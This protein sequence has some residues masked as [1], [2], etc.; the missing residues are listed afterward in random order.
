MEQNQVNKIALFID[1]D[2]IGLSKG[3]I[4]KLISYVRKRGRLIV[5][6]AYADWS[7]FDSHKKELIENSI[8]LIE[9]PS[10]S[11]GKNAADIKLAVDAMEVARDKPYIDTMIIAGG[12]SDYMPLISKLRE[13]DKYVIVI[14]QR[15]DISKRLTGYSDEVVVVNDITDLKKAKVLPKTSLKGAYELLQES[16]EYLLS[17]S[18]KTVLGQVKNQMLLSDPSFNENALGFDRFISFLKKAAEDR[19]VYLEKDTNDTWVHLFDEEKAL[20]S[21]IEYELAH[22]DEATTKGTVVRLGKKPFGFI[23]LDT[24]KE[25]LYFTPKDVL[26]EDFRNL[27]EGDIVAFTVHKTNKQYNRAKSVQLLKHAAPAKA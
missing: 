4:T 10:N 17:K 11:R 1:Y 24:T 25:R 3:K 14:A 27:R 20:E 9:M 26:N 16:L 22:M 21:E 5:K 7:N 15:N 8:D 12:D 13:Y 6:M 18:R 2:N 23:E 19:I